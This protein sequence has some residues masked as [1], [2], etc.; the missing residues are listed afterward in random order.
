[1]DYFCFLNL[2]NNKM[3]KNVVEML[4][5]NLASFLG[6]A[7]KWLV[8]W[9][10]ETKKLLH[11]FH[12]LRKEDLIG[13]LEGTHRIIKKVNGFDSDLFKKGEAISVCPPHFFQIR[14]TSVMEFFEP[15]IKR[16]KHLKNPVISFDK[17]IWNLFSRE[18]VNVIFSLF[19]VAI[20]RFVEGLTHQQIFDEAEKM[21]IKKTVYSYLEALSIIREAILSGEVDKKKTGVVTYFRITGK[22]TL[23]RFNASRYDDGRLYLIVSKVLSNDEWPSGYGACFDN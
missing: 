8:D 23:Y 15:V 6:L 9:S 4:E 10:V 22:N 13:L 21:E 14:E 1:M 19:Y 11:F 20:Y 18:S 3:A 7:K 17:D 16:E 5:E 12:N 2:N